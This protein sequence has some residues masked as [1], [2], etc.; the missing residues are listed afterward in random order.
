MNGICDLRG[1]IRILKVYYTPVRPRLCGLFAG[2]RL[3]PWDQNRQRA[4]EPLQ[5]LCLP[6]GELSDYWRTLGGFGWQNRD[7]PCFRFPYPARLAL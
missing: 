7:T 2:A 5:M 1:S 4:G 3:F 6:E